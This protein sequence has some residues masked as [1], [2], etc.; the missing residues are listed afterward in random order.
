MKVKPIRFKEENLYRHVD[1]APPPKGEEEVSAIKREPHRTPAKSNGTLRTRTGHLNGSM[2]GEFDDDD[3]G[4]LFDGVELAGSNADDSMSEEPAPKAL[5][6]A[7]PS[8]APSVLS[9][10]GASYVKNGGPPQRPPNQRM[11]TAPNGR[12]QNGV[13]QSHP[14]QNQQSNASGRPPANLQNSRGPP[15][16]AQGNRRPPP[17]VDIHAVPKP[18]NAPLQAQANQPLRPTPPQ[19]QQQVKPGGP[20]TTTP[21]RPPVGFVTSR[22]AELLQNSESAASSL[23]NLPAFNPHAESPVPK[24][25]RTPGV[26]YTRSIPIKRGEISAP[27][28][29]A[30][31]LGPAANTSNNGGGSAFTR[32]GPGARG[33]TNFVNPA[34]DMNRRI[35]MPGAGAG[36]GGGMNQGPNRSAYKPPMKRPPLSDVSNQRGESDEPD[37]KRQKVEPGSGPENGGPGVVES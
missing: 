14:P 35:G 4:N 26:D 2:G 29:A 7:Q 37:P 16:P 34:Q 9:S 10:S 31:N 22:A 6:T 5:E 28:L 13:Q 18:P 11:Q 30:P 36:A 8:N 27:P 12:G 25:Q 3:D 19:Q 20:A 17:T 33:N 21:A 23:T 24:A 1:F 15:T 32:P